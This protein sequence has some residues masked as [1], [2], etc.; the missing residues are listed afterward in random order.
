[1][2]ECGHGS[3]MQ[4]Q[5]SIILKWHIYLHRK[6]TRSLSGN[7]YHHKHANSILL[8]LPYTITLHDINKS[9]LHHAI[10][11]L[12]NWFPCYFEFLN[13]TCLCREFSPQVSK[14]TPPKCSE[15]KALP[16]LK[17]YYSAGYFQNIFFILPCQNHWKT[18]KGINLIFVFKGKRIFEMNQK[19]KLYSSQT[20]TIWIYV[21]I[22]SL[23]NLLCQKENRLHYFSD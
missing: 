17:L 6:I 7:H 8:F 2:L 20:L 5:G 19:Q 4:L 23:G 10:E 15:W 18:L 1:M 11:L 22:P 3:C 14:R 16:V 21:N 9:A 12:I 13:F